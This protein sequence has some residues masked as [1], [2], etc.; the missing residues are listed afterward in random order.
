MAYKLKSIPS[1]EEISK[2]IE[3][4]SSTINLI[5]TRCEFDKRE[6]YEEIPFLTVYYF[7]NDKP[8][9]VE[10]LRCNKD[11]FEEVK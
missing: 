2:Y 10:K 5:M 6:R 4:S 7:N 8:E 3:E 11:W 9:F 1:K